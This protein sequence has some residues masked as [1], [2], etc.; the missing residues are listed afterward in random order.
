MMGRRVRRAAGRIGR[1]AGLGRSP[2]GA[3]SR[4]ALPVARDLVG[5]PRVRH[6]PA[7]DARPSLVVLMPHLSVGR[8]TGG[9]NTVFHITERIAARLSWI[10]NAAAA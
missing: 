5:G 1:A 2:A 4:D 3:A 10:G 7:L 9:P 8:M 6:D